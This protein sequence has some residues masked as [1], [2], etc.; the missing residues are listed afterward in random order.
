MRCRYP[1]RCAAPR[2]G[3][4]L[5]RSGDSCLAAFR[6][7]HSATKRAENMRTMALGDYRR[8]DDRYTLLPST[9][10]TVASEAGRRRRQEGAH[11]K[12][13]SSMTT[14]IRAAKYHANAW[15]AG[16]MKSSL[17]GRRYR[18]D[19]LDADMR[20]TPRLFTARHGARTLMPSAYSAGRA[21]EMMARATRAHGQGARRDELAAMPMTN[22]PAF[23]IFGKLSAL[24]AMAISIYQSI[25]QLFSR[26][27][28]AWRASGGVSLRAERSL[29][30]FQVAATM[31]VA[32]HDDLDFF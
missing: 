26:R 3:L 23:G 8:Y 32:S 11:A 16:D 6:C 15:W 28:Y 9:A 5:L 2:H 30:H 29:L 25:Q 7:R 4:T 20:A 14:T 19:M 10:T 31:P 24:M 13:R 18:I 12:R 17:D 27:L 21:A 1:A 22:T